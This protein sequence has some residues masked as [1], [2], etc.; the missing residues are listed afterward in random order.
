M[1][2]AYICICICICDEETA[3]LESLEG[4]RGE[5][6]TKPPL[7][8]IS[9]LNDQ[10]PVEST[11]SHPSYTFR[12]PER[13]IIDTLGTVTVSPRLDNLTPIVLG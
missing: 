10:P 12:M 3:L 2:L 8:T 13:A 5:I 1:A 9:G 4:R 6:R 11:Q 7:P